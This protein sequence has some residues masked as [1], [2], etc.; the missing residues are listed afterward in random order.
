MIIVEINKQSFFKEI[1]LILGK[2]INSFFKN[3]D[4]YLR[5]VNKYLKLND[6]N[7][8][9]HYNLTIRLINFDKKKC[10]NFLSLKKY[11][12]TN[13]LLTTKIFDEVT[14]NIFAPKIYPKEKTS[15]LIRPHTNIFPKVYL[16]ELS[17]VLVRSN[18]S[19]IS[20]GN[21]AIFQDLYDP[22]KDYT[23]EEINGIHS[24]YPKK[25]LIIFF[26]YHSFANKLFN[27]AASFLTAFSNNY[28]HWLTEV[29]PKIAVFCSLKKFK[30]IPLIIDAKLHPN[31]IQSLEL[32]VEEKRE[33]FVLSKN[34]KVKVKKLYELSSTGYAP[35]GQ[36]NQNFNRQGVFSPDALRLVRNK[37]FAAI[38]HLPIKNS[39]KK[40]YLKRNSY[41]RILINEKEIIKVL[42]NKGYEIIE[43]EK[44]SFLQQVSLIKNAKYISGPVGASFGN[45]IFASLD[46]KINILAGAVE[47]MPYWYWQNIALTLDLKVNYILGKINNLLYGPHSNFTIDPK[48]ILKVA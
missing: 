37:I 24:L 26:D 13:Q 6:I 21:Q 16:T 39:P 5:K 34:L 19:L 7:L 12:M 4:V 36:K 9:Y 41:N 1:Y 29:L 44:I 22:V 46:S 40:I 17:N 25:N 38:E 33:I 48:L 11:S 18:T 32:I 10:L 30:N 45:L 28:A 47:N 15:I 42:I 43:P 2:L 23:G 14:T 20:V 27:S 3:I 31:I 8:M 35:I